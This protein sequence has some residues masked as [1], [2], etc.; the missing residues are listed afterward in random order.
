M[1]GCCGQSPVIVTGAQPARVDVET[2]LMCDVLPDGTVAATVLV[3]PVYDTSTGARIATRITAPSTGATY[4]PVGTI[5][6]CPQSPD[7]AS[8]TTPTTTVGLCLA[9]STPIAVTVVRD[10][11][12]VV[13]Q[14]GWINLTTGAFSAGA[15]P[16]GTVSCGDSQSVQVSGTFCDIDATGTVVGLVLIEYS[17]A[18]DGTIASVRLVDATTGA[19]YTPAGTITT[20]PAG[21]EQ[22]EQDL[23]QLCD[24]A[25]DGTATAFIRD[26]RRDELGAIT[27]HSDYLLDGT[28]Y[29]PTGTV[30]VCQAAPCLHCETIELCD[31]AS[32]GPVTLEPDVVNTAWVPYFPLVAG[33]EA[34]DVVGAQNLW[35]G[36]TVTLPADAAKPNIATSRTAAAALRVACPPCIDDGGSVTVSVS[37]DFERLGPDPACSGSGNLRLFNGTAV[38][39]IAQAPTDAAVGVSGTLAVAAAV[40]IA[41]LLAGNIAVGVQFETAQN[42]ASC[43][44]REGG[45]QLSD[46]TTSVAPIT[47]NAGPGCGNT[48]LRTTC[49]NCAGEVISATDL[50]YNGQP[51]TPVGTVAPCAKPAPCETSAC[52]RCETF[53]LCDSAATC[54]PDALVADTAW[55][56]RYLTSGD[57]VPGVV[58]NRVNVPGG[59]DPFWTGGSVT[60]PNNAADPDPGNNGLHYGIA[61]SIEA[62][63]VC[64]DCIAP[65]DQVTIT[66]SGQATNDGPGAGLL[67]NGR[68]R[69]LLDGGEADGMVPQLAQVTDANRPPG[70]TWSF[71]AS[72]TVPWSDVLAGR[73]VVTLD[74][75]TK[76]NGAFKQW[77]ASGFELCVEPV[78]PRAGC[79]SRFRRTVCRDCSG[80]IVATSDVELDGITPYT[81][82]GAVGACTACTPPC[83]T[84]AVQTFQLCDLNPAVEPD[85]NGLRCATPFLR[86]HTYGCDGTGTF[87]DTA[88][89]G[90]T[91]YTPVQA[92]NCGDSPPSL[93]EQV[94]NT[95]SVAADPADPTGATFIYTVANSENPAQTGT[96]TMTASEPP[97][98]GCTTSP[99][100]PVWNAPVTFVFEPDATVLQLASVLRVDA[101]DW[102]DWEDKFIPGGG[103]VG[104]GTWPVPDLVE[105]DFGF[106]NVSATRWH[107]SAA[108]NT[109]HFYFSGPPAAV[110]MGSRNDGGGLAC[111]APS[112]GFITLV[113]GPPCGGC[114]NCELLLL[115]DDGADDPATIRGTG[116]SSGTLA[117][118][119]AWSSRGNAPTL[120][121]TYDNA[122]GAWWGLA[123]FPNTVFPP[124]TWSFSKPVTAEFSVYIRH[125]ASG[126]GSDNTAQLPAGLQVVALPAGY[127]YDPVTG[128]LT[129]TGDTGDDPCPYLTDPR[130]ATSARF[131]TPNPVTSV[132]ARY[133]GARIANCGV[134]GNYKIG[135]F[136]VSWGGQFLRH[137][138]RNCDGEVTSTTDTL[139]DAVTPY[140]PAGAV[141]ACGG[142]PDCS[143]TQLCVQATL[144]ERFEFL[145]N[146][147]NQTSGAVDGDWTWS[148]NLTGPWFP[149]YQVG[150]FPGWTTTDPGTPQ[151]AAHW[152]APH[153]N[154]GLLNT[155]A[156]G[157]GPD[158]P[159]PGEWYARASFTLP[160]D[161]EPSSI[162]IS[163]TALNADQNAVEWRLNGGAW[164]PVNANHAQ[165]A[166]QL[167]PAAVPGAQPGPNEIIVHVSETVPGGGAAG[168]ILHLIAE[169]QVPEDGLRSWTRMVCSDDAVHYVDDTGA[170]QDALPE[171]WTIAPCMG[172]SVGGACSRQVIERCR[173]DDT[174]GDGI[175][176]V[177]YVELWAVDPC[178]SSGDPVLLGTY[179]ADD[180]AVPYTPV[181]PVDCAVVSPPS[182]L[183]T[184][185][186]AVTGTAAQN[187][188]TEFPTLQ[189]VTLTVVA[190]SVL[191][192]M[193][194]GTNVPVPAGA[195]VTWSVVRDADAQ[196]DAAAFTGA[197]ASASYL[198]IWTHRG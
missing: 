152:V 177:R 159:A 134:F 38:V 3:E 48:F 54:A 83:P 132:G 165:P 174:D 50:D 98:G 9:D 47:V 39:S 108:N 194:D 149:T 147:G 25:D 18:A 154:S 57:S 192:S 163:A 4:T 82:I 61:G 176:D 186:R 36:Q 101:I 191:A 58:E 112:F 162:R 106:S 19:T 8:P 84:V 2:Q 53:E 167:A 137:I 144:T 126:T 160:A 62:S 23:I 133:L 80:E 21:V 52:L 92:V 166:F 157:E 42:N 69:I 65:S 173:C 29:T 74:L 198:L 155:G 77:T 110:A 172:T 17:Y 130:V 56:P 68:W 141:A 67:T 146:P 123:S 10:C 35:Q 7:C 179:V 113:P 161:A 78:T 97:G 88:L 81:P 64:P 145:S 43:G 103:P 40:P 164:Q 187:L 1:S 59:G 140:T 44:T 169:Y 16:V 170:R 86:H 46:F 181:D 20:C 60:F 37:V 89:D 32:Q 100:A 14:E 66:V 180:L 197:D 183:M 94:W 114:Q 55:S 127:L 182:T 131:R 15:P 151:G 125:H 72:A 96:V 107:S 41:D 63:D 6:G 11:E 85:A 150:V 75:E 102:D 49:R 136:A 45:W 99:T 138:C 117:N 70:T 124:S 193:S 5:Q 135:A 115:C 128:I 142:P 116:L 122:D 129:S 26:F 79:G 148:P 90:S 91:P 156:P 121:S 93:R 168:I 13:T 196:L 190:G 185:A 109:G 73:I 22:P 28:A 153:P 175:G 189:S 95:T 12:G 105:A 171:F 71:T 34:F 111:V 139:L 33:N 104:G 87:H 188:A 195:T 143:A 158:V 51:Y 24:V 31:S 119:V 76:S 184:G 118:G 27:G 178:V 120:P 30:G